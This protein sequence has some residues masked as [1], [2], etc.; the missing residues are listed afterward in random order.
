MKR[1]KSLTVLTWNGED[2]YE[3]DPKK[4]ESI[5]WA[6]WNSDKLHITKWTRSQ[7][8]VSTWFGLGSR[9]V[10][11]IDQK[12]LA[13]YNNEYWEKVVAREHYEVE[14]K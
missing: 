8:K 10:V 2:E 1:M 7:R 13:T 12:I 11:D 4:H 9:T 5:D 6:S 3:V 14:E